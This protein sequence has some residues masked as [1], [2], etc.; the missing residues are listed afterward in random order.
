MT[1]AKQ[2]VYTTTDGRNF[3]GA[4]L[5]T[6]KA[7]AAHQ[8]SLDRKQRLTDLVQKLTEDAGQHA[9]T[10]DFIV[11]NADEVI[12]ALTIVAPRAPRKPKDAA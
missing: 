5:E 11:A 1:L 7:A 8:R 6:R 10:I 12:N 3:V 2:N 9:G 4:G